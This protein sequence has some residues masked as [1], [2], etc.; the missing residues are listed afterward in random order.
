[1]NKFPLSEVTV[2]KAKDAKLNVSCVMRKNV[3][4]TIEN[5]GKQY[6]FGQLY[7]RTSTKGLLQMSIDEAE[8]LSKELEAIVK[9]ARELEAA[10]ANGKCTSID[11]FRLE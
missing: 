5:E 6:L 11:D 9:G 2:E 4:I 3:V 8:V 1:M 7:E 10:I